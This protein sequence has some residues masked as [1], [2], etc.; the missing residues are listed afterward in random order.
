MVGYGF[1]ASWRLLSRLISAM[2]SL[3]FVRH[4]WIYFIISRWLASAL[5][6]IIY[7]RFTFDWRIKNAGFYYARF[8]AEI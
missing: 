7:A 8:N 5:L 4:K 1:A 3:I 6:S 2:I